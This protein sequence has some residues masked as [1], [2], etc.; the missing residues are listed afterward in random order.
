VYFQPSP[1]TSSLS[2]TH[3]ASPNVTSSAPSSARGQCRG[4]YRYPENLPDPRNCGS[5]FPTREP[6]ATA[7]RL[8]LLNRSHT[9]TKLMILSFSSQLLLCCLT[10]T[11]IPEKTLAFPQ[12][13]DR[14]VPFIQHLWSLPR[15]SYG[16]RK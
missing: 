16:Q 15:Y 14:A 13:R 10:N 7:L 8:S 9:A 11:N 4:S 1:S 2:S 3:S 12:E 5:R 6:T